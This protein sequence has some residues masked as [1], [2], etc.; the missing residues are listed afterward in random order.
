MFHRDTKGP[1][2]RG[3]IADAHPQDDAPF[4]DDIQGRHVLSDVHWVVQGQQ[5]DR[6]A[7]VQAPRLGRHCRGHN[8]RRGQEAIFILV[9]LPKKA[10]I[11]TIRLG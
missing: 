3:L 5:D 1:E 10:G 11:E 6:G 4:R 9:V 7:N 8:Q 2:V